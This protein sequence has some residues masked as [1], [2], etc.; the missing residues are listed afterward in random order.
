MC[1]RVWE[2]EWNCED[3]SLCR[4]LLGWNIPKYCI[5]FWIFLFVLGWLTGTLVVLHNLFFSCKGLNLRLSENVSKWF[6]FYLS[7][8]NS[9]HTVIW[10]L[11]KWLFGRWGVGFTGF[12]RGAD[13]I[14]R[15]TSR[16][17]NPEEERLNW[18]SEG[19]TPQW[20]YCGEWVLISWEWFCLW[21]DERY[22][23][24]HH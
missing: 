3:N 4:F 5:H 9:L 22:A 23:G 13:I 7:T 11:D 10:T 16:T 20:E 8:H 1:S 19:R 2:D 24:C 18:V 15:R 14:T 6:L 12:H 17:Q 21:K